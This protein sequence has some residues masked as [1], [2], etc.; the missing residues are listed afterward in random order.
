MNDILIVGVGGAGAFLANR[1][2]LEVHSTAIAINTDER[3]LAECGLDRRM[4]I[5]PTICKGAAAKVPSRGR[6]A[7]EESSLD[8]E[9]M[10]EGVRVL[11]LL[12]GLGGG[13]GT[14]ATPV[15]AKLARDRRLDVI[16]AVT[17]PLKVEEFRRDHALEGLT[18]LRSTGATVFVHDHAASNEANCEAPLL[19]SFEASAKRLLNM[20]SLQL[21]RNA[22]LNT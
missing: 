9:T 2:Q 19:E 1:F 8:L 14:G 15:V 4:L 7:A 13:T 18:E 6:R 11:I 22:G 10:L 5:G 12:A 16:V 20:A 3:A 17:L 21:K